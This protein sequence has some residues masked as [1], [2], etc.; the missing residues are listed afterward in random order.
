MPESITNNSYRFKTS[1][2]AH[3]PCPWACGASRPE[4]TVP[5]SSFSRGLNEHGGYWSRYPETVGPRSQAWPGSG[6]EV[7]VGW[8]TQSSCMI[9]SLDELPRA[10]MCV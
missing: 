10:S 1:G 5:W 2:T 8:V 7:P 6:T 9:G 3:G 4:M